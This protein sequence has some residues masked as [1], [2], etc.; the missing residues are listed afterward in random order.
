MKRVFKPSM[1][2]LPPA[3][4]RLWSELNKVVN[5]GFVLYGGTAGALRLGHRGSVDFDFFCEKPL[6]R[7]A[8][9]AACPFVEQ[10]TIIQDDRNS[11]S[12][13]VPYGDSERNHVKVSLLWRDWFWPSRRTGL[14]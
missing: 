5:L 14:H 13:L 10:S 8:I 3:Q 2:V 4:Q 11:W 7:E 6:D 12:L 9:K 1:E